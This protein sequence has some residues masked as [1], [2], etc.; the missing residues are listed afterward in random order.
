QRAEIRRRKTMLT[1]SQS[2]LELPCPMTLNRSSLRSK[3]PIRWRQIVR[4]V[5]ERTVL[6]R[7]RAAIIIAIGALLFLQGW[8]RVD[9]FGESPVVRGIICLVAGG[10]VYLFW[11]VLYQILFYSMYHY[12]ICEHNMVIRKG[13]LCR[14]EIS[15][16][17]TRITDVYLDQ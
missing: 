15:L 9:L 10:T 8:E 3:F 13:V 17:L 16:P 11:Q 12:D 7:N 4:A 1:A 5:I 6:P 2:A 14:R